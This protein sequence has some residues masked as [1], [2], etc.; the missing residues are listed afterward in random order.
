MLR[1]LQV[2]RAE[3][4]PYDLGYQHASQCK[5]LIRRLARESLPDEITRSGQADFT[6]VK[7]GTREYEAHIKSF[8][9]HLL[10][11]IRGIADGAGIDYEEALMLQCRG[12]LVYWA[13]TQ[14]E[15]TSFAIAKSRSAT[16]G[17]IVGQNLDLAPSF[18]EFGVI[19]CLY[20]KKGP[21][22][23]TWTLAGT[24]GHTGINSAGLARCGNVL[25]CPGWRVGVP[26]TVLWRRILEQSSVQAAV[27]LIGSSFRAKSNAFVLG[28]AR[29]A[30]LA[31]EATVTDHRCLPPQDGLVMHTNHYLHP[32]LQPQEKHANLPDTQTRLTRL[33]ELLAGHTEPIGPTDLKII[34]KD[35]STAPYSIC[36]HKGP[37]KTVVSVLFHPHAGSMEACPGNPCQGEYSLYEL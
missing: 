9:P 19:L 4:G 13:R 32:D 34:L 20:P 6:L 37:S 2:I 8:A 14:L 36:K 30:I 22:I 35:H 11:E 5:D 26:T 10:D 27:D 31:V 17:V 16:G 18:E 7:K 29:G 1:S 24:L 21:S 3:G 25:L 12:E 33:K 23:L 28:D 15:C